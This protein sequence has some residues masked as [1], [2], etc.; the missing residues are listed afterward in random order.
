MNALARVAIGHAAGVTGSVVVVSESPLIMRSAACVFSGASDPSMAEACG[1]AAASL[2]E[3]GIAFS[4][5]SVLGLAVLVT[6][7]HGCRWLQK[8]YGLPRWAGPLVFLVGCPVLAGLLGLVA[9]FPG[10]DAV[11]M[12]L[13]LGVPVGL[14]SS[15]Y[16]VL[17]MSIAK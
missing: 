3:G 11:G 12:G 7:M 17:L 16:W 13:M 4:V 14:A 15:A 8:W 1:R 10:W 6:I 9:A 5:A 2:G